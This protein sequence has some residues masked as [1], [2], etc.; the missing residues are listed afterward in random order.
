MKP[1]LLLFAITSLILWVLEKYTSI[2]TKEI[3]LIQAFFFCTFLIGHRLYSISRKRPT[4]QFHIFYFTS[5][6]LRFF[7]AII[8]LFFLI[9]R[10]GN[11]SFV[12]IVDF[13]FLYLIY[14]GFEIYFL[15]DNLRTDFK[16]GDES[17]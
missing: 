13:L 6:I 3:W 16:K 4:S 8:F 1:F 2:I 5:M 7:G 17:K 9:N 11:Q 10:S 15:I 12:F 14:T